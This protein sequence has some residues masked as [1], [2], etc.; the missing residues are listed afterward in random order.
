M[1]VGRRQIKI[2]INKKGQAEVTTNNIS[3][4]SCKAFSERYEQALGTTEKEELK[5][6][7]YETVEPMVQ[8][9]QQTI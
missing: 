1:S 5:P 9:V 3:G 4:S 7:F 6:E 2:R 8:K